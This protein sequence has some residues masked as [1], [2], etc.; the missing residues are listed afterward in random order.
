MREFHG[1]FVADTS[2]TD[3]LDHNAD[4]LVVEVCHDNLE[5]LVFFTDQVLDWDLDIFECD[6]GGATA[7]DTLA[8]H[9]AGADAGAAL[10]QKNGNTVH[11]WAAGTNSGGEVIGPD[12]IGDPL[13][14][15]I[16]DVM[17]SIFRE[18][19]FAV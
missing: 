13:L 3:G 5:P 4:S 19:S 18:L 17:L 12:A 7:P 16:D 2:E 14:L 11:A 8:V 6:V 9:A 1:L 10:D 15:T